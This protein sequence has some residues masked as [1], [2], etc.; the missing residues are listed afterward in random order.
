MNDRYMPVVDEVFQA[1]LDCTSHDFSLDD[2]LR[3][4]LH[5]ILRT[6][7]R[8]AVLRSHCDRFGHRPDDLQR[9]IRKADSTLVFHKIACTYCGA[10]LKEVDE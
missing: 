9:T 2:P 8:K 10:E 3:T 7:G 4:K 6:G 5:L 1:I